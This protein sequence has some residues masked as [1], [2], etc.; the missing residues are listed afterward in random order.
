M[1]INTKTLEWPVSEQDIKSLYPNTSFAEDFVAP[2]PFAVIVGV[3]EPSYNPITQAVRQMTPTVDQTGQWRQTWEVYALEAVQVEA[4]QAAQKKQLQDS[5]VQATQTRLD[6]FAK[7][8]NYDGILS[9]AT[10]ATSTNAKFQA[11]GQYGVEARDATWSKLYEIMAEVE[12]GARPMPESFADVE[13]EL[14][15]LE[16][17]LA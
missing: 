11:E 9:L 3:A 14:P 5:V 1:Y 2:E 16:W 12:S 8:R 10:Y 4:N 6:G 15:V 7:T 13:P 17:P